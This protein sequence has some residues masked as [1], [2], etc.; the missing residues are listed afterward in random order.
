MFYGLLLIFVSYAAWA[1]SDAFIKFVDGALPPYE[2]AFYGAV[3]G[4]VALPFVKGKDET[5]LD[6]FRPIHVRLWLL[7]MVMT[8]ISIVG[9]VVAFTHLSM[10]E[11][12]TLL[13]L[14]PIFVCILSMLFLKEQIRWRRW[15]AITLGFIGVL[16]VLQPGFR[17]LTIGHLGAI[18]AAPAG[19]VVVLIFRHIAGREKRLT[20]YG[21]GLLGPI[22]I[23]GLMTLPNYSQPQPVEWAYLVAYGFFAA[24]GSLLTIAAAQRIPA[25]LIAIPQ[26]S[27]MVWALIFG[28]FIFHDH[29]DMSMG[30]GIILIL[31]SSLLIFIREE[32]RG[33]KLPRPVMP[34]EPAFEQKSAQDIEKEAQTE[35]V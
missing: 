8:T 4:L 14:M 21:S 3:V 18:V 23:C 25:S 32:E 7:R 13:F 2:V 10:A 9:S 15:L 11:A 29:L 27:Q 34:P 17:E 33:V 35:T 20:L 22:V 26:Y 6:L 19:A 31:C 30:L 16:V 28:Y 1:V 24:C 5:W 12:F